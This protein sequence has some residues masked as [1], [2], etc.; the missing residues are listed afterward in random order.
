M[1]IDLTREETDTLIELLR[2]E[3][4]DTRTEITHTDNSK[5]KEEVKQHK[6][7]LNKILST[8]EQSLAD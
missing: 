7:S 5:F 3:I 6:Q 4:S 8:L 2:R 1:N